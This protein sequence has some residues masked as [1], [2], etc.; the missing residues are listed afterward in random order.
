LNKVKLGDEID[1]IWNNKSYTYKV[2]SID[3]VPPKYTAIE[4]HSLNPE[5]TLFTC[6][7]LWLPKNRLVV[8]ASL[9]TKL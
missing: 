8:V 1:V 2:S 7:P 9:E 4:N 6:T 3:Q 5:L